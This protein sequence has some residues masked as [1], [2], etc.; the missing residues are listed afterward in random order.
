MSARVPRSLVK[1]AQK[2]A[3]V[4]HIFTLL[5]FAA[6][7]VAVVIA[8]PDPSNLWVSIF[9][10]VGSFTSA[11]AAALAQITTEDE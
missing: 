1:F 2:W 6:A 5:V 10:L 4:W 9:V 11:V 3:M 7:L 8:F